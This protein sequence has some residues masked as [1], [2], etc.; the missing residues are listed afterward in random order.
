[1]RL[2]LNTESIRDKVR[3]VTDNTRLR[4]LFVSDGS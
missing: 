3:K 2:D 4:E 1:V